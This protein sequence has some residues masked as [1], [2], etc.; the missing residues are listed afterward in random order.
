MIEHGSKWRLN[1]GRNFGRV[2]TAACNLSFFGRWR[3]RRRT[4]GPPPFSSMNS[5]QAPENYRGKIKTMLPQMSAVP[6]SAS[7][8]GK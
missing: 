3:F 7:T 1:V 8:F 6:I 2:A 5:T 4:P